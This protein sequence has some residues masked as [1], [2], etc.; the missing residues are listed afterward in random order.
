MEITSGLFIRIIS[1]VTNPRNLKIRMAA[2]KASYGLGFKPT[3][4]SLQTQ[5]GLWR[6][7]AETAV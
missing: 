6:L 5:L 2:L 3:E 7:K 1:K 4:H